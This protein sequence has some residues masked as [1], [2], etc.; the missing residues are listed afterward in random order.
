VTIHKICPTVLRIV[1]NNR[2]KIMEAG[3]VC[4]PDLPSSNDP[5]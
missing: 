5:L 3:E 2:T 4:I 1:K